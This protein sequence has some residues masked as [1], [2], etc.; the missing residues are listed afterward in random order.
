MTA[1]LQDP[2]I[3]V[4]AGLVLLLAELLV[5]GYVMLSFS[6]GAF[7]MA[8]GLAA[9]SIGLGLVVPDPAGTGGALVLLLVWMLFSGLAAL[10]IWRFRPGRAGGEEEDDVNDFR[11]RM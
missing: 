1:W 3:W 10:L 11:N 7:G 6:L 8:L 5:P 2:W 4:G 9:W